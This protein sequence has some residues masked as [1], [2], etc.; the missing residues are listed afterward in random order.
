MYLALATLLSKAGRLRRVSVFSPRSSRR[1]AL[2][3][4]D[5]LIYGPAFGTEPLSL[6]SKAVYPLVSSRPRY[7]CTSKLMMRLRSHSMNRLIAK[8]TRAL[9]LAHH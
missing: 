6:A 3:Y 7:R 2:C 5:N 1:V 4:S 8:W 9:A